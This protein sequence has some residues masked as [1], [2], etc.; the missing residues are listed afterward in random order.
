MARDCF[1]NPE[2]SKYKRGSNKGT[3]TGSVE[4]LVA[5]VDENNFGV[6]L[7]L[8]NIEHEL[9]DKQGKNATDRDKNEV[10]NDEVAN[11]DIK[12]TEMQTAVERCSI[13]AARYTE[14]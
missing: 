2:S 8:S 12:G 6:E 1:T 7:F 13:K 9:Q 3:T 10:K 4:V 5:T 11:E 14:V